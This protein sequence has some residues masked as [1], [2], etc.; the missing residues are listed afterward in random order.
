VSNRII[1]VLMQSAQV[2]VDLRHGRAVLLSAIT[3]E[4]GGGYHHFAERFRMLEELVKASGLKWTFLRASDFAAN[5][6]I[7]VPQIRA[8]NVVRGAYG[9]AATSPIHERD[10]AAV[11]AEAFMQKEHIGKSY[12]ITGPQSLTQFERVSIIGE[13]IGKDLHFEEISAER[14]RAAMLAQGAPPE[15]PDRMLGYLSACLAQPGP[16]TDTIEKVFGRYP[17]YFAT[18][19]KEHRAIFK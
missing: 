17:L 3:V 18:W 5:S 6:T 4:Y 2:P 8:S 14:A 9:N 12:A 19:V 1:Y 7:W 11:A 10:I 16:T 15:V 13:V